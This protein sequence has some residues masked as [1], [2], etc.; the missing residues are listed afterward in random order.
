MTPSRFHF[1]GEP[2]TDGVVALRRVSES[3]VDQIVAACQD[4]A[5]KRFTSSIPDPYRRSDARHWIALHEKSLERE[6]PLAVVDAEQHDRLLGMSGLHDAAW[7]HRRCDTGYWTVPDA[8]G[9]GYA[10]RALALVA[11][12]GF[13]E[14]GFERIGLYADVENVGSHRVAE[15]A[16]F[17]R[18]GVLKRYLILRGTPRD[19]VVYGRTA[20]Q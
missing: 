13:G 17:A 1:P 2:I 19:C 16:G 7:P 6:M 4:S 14:F 20:S 12:W 11:E 18:E 3:D 9:K 10:S 5:I 15:R 8:R